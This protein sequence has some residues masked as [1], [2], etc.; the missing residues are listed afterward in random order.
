MTNSVFEA[1]WD[2]IIVGSGAGGGVVAAE[3]ANQGARVLVIERGAWIPPDEIDQDELAMIARLYRDGGAQTNTDADM[4]VLQGSCV[5]GSTVLTNA[6]CFRMPEDVRRR[7]EDYGWRLTSEELSACSAYVEEAMH[8]C[9]LDPR[10]HNPA[11]HR[12]AEGMRALGLTPGRFDKAFDRCIGCGYCNVGCGFGRK[13]DS[14]TVWI[15]RALEAGCELRPRTEALR[16]VHR[17]GHVDGL[18]CKDLESGLNFTLR[19][20]RYVLACGALHTPELLLRSGLGGRHVGKRTSFNAGAIVFAEY[21]EVVDGFD[22]DQMCVH[23]FGDGYAIEQIQN[24]PM[25]FALTMPGWFD[26]HHAAM[27]RYRHRVAAG[28]LVP[29]R[30]V[31][32]VFRG[33]GSK[34]LTRWFDHPNLAFQLPTEDIESFRRGFEMIARI[35]L[36]SGARVVV[37]PLATYTEIR[38]ENDLGLIAERLHTQRDLV[39]FG[40]SHPQGG[41][42]MGDDPSRDVVAPNYRVYDTNCVH[43]CDASLFPESVR[44]NPMISIMAVA[45][46]AAS[47]IGSLVDRNQASAVHVC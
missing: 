1:Q 35:F 12:M 32:R 21:D 45:K 42:C 38:S 46:H 34:L 16:F 4:F 47:I 39:G 18:V 31:G 43:V 24:P 40:S 37:P 41:A 36:A 5:G 11:S 28:V 14:S 17:A 13:R 26:E 27:L 44:V 3:L 15:P 9:E 20:K 33:L 10:L 6:V 2:V 7:F 30:P 25:S 19:A 23:Y 29:T 8:V 22:G